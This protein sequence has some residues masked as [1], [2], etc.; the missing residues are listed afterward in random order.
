METS[1]N[2]NK[3]FNYLLHIQPKNALS[4]VNTVERNAVQ[5]GPQWTRV[6]FQRSVLAFPLPCRRSQ[7]GGNATSDYGSKHFLSLFCVSVL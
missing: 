2:K 7:E 5:Y 1:S 4:G 6:T 3:L